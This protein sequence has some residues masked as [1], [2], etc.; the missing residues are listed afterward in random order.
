VRQDE[1]YD[2]FDPG[3]VGRVRRALERSERDALRAA[4]EEH[5][6]VVSRRDGDDRLVAVRA[7][8]RARSE[9]YRRQDEERLEREVAAI[10]YEFEYGCSACGQRFG[11]PEL[12]TD[13][14][15]LTATFLREVRLYG[16]RPARS[17]DRFCTSAAEML[18]AGLI[19]TPDGVW[20][21][22]GHPGSF[23]WQTRGTGKL[24][25]GATPPEV[26]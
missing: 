26:A 21:N 19:Q 4:A 9:E 5:G 11:S 2:E 1:R 12:V 6:M 15:P 10:L 8:E 14:R 3:A 20:R 23:G 18:E 16:I 17:G 25:R 7:D 24:Y 22:P 13:H